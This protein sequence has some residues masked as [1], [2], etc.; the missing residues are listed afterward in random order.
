[1]PDGGYLW[2]HQMSIAHL[3]LLCGCAALVWTA[4][5]DSQKKHRQGPVDNGR[6]ESQ[7]YRRHRIYNPGVGITLNP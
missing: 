3:W 2:N 4:W 6:I 1:M 5:L 7:S